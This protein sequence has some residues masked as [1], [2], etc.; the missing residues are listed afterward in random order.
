[1]YLQKILKATKR[2]YRDRKGGSSNRMKVKIGYVRYDNQ[3]NANI[4]GM[5]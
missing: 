1:M 5:H 3:C 4:P 2:K